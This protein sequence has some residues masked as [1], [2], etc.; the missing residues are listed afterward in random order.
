VKLLK[1]NLK[2]YVYVYVCNVYARY[3]RKLKEGVRSFGA[4][5]RCDCDLLDVGAG[6]LARSSRKAAS[7]L[8]C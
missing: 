6:N 3:S 7:A 1:Y 8:N 2:V 5:I 4:G